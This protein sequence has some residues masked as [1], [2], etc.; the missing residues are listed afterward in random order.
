MKVGP[1]RADHAVRRPGVGVVGVFVEVIAGIEMEVP[2]RDDVVVLAAVRGDERGDRRGHVRAARDR[3]RTPSQKSFC[4]STMINAR[5]MTALPRVIPHEKATPA[6]AGTS[7]R[8]RRA[9][10]DLRNLKA[11][12]LLADRGAP[13]RYSSEELDMVAVGVQT[14]VHDVEF[15][16]HQI[17]SVPRQAAGGRSRPELL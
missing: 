2:G 7:V 3:Q 13:D 5:L 4:T 10:G 8:A 17:D 14:G 12:G 1:G 9:F 6:E 16:H 15:G 11:A